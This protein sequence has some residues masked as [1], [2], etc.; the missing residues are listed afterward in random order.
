V[1]KPRFLRIEKTRLARGIDWNNSLSKPSNDD[2][3]LK[4]Q[5]PNITLRPPSS[6]HKPTRRGKMVPESIRKNPQALCR[7][8]TMGQQL[9]MW[10]GNAISDFTLFAQSSRSY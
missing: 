7:T 9:S 6:I 4:R 8:G 3:R 2:P 10:Q 5:Y 1:P